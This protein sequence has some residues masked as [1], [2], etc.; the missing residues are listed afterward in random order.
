MQIHTKRAD[1]A[2]TAKN[3]AT[4]GNLSMFRI[5]NEIRITTFQW[6]FNIQ[7]ISIDKWFIHVNFHKIYT[8]L[9][10]CIISDCNPLKMAQTL[11]LFLLIDLTFELSPK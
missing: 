2:S 7:Y 10:A 9:F 11:Y 3:V 8:S 1:I 5:P 4:Y 6:G